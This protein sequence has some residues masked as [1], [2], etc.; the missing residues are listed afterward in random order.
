[1]I[2]VKPTRP[3]QLQK[4]L[5]GA[6][7]LML[8]LLLNAC[9]SPPKKPELGISIEAIQQKEPAEGEERASLVMLTQPVIEKNM[10]QAIS[11]IEALGSIEGKVVMIRVEHLDS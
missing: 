11:A 8:A 9:A 4:W 6:L 7:V 3:A 5:S 1:M 10:K 2:P